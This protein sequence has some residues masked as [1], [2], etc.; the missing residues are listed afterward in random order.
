MSQ[1]VDTLRK[2]P[3]MYPVIVNIR[4]RCPELGFEEHELC[5]AGDEDVLD[6]LSSTVAGVEAAVNRERYST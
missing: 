3:W 5:G 4:V 2:I 6:V 1:Q